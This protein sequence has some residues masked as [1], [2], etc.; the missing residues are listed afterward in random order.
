MSCALGLRPKKNP[1]SQKIAWFFANLVLFKPVAL[2]SLGKSNRPM[3]ITPQIR[4]GLTYSQGLIL[5]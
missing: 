2:G 1:V 3:I 5:P 4:N